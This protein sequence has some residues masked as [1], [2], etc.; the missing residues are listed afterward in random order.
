MTA[1]PEQLHELLNYCIGFAEQMLVDSGEFYP[2]GAT[3]GNDGRV[4]AVGGHI[5]SEHPNPRELYR[6]L[7][8]A[9]SAQGRS[10][11]ILAAAVASNVDIPPK[12]SPKYPDGLRVQVESA[13]YSRYI[14]VPY[15]LA[16]SGF[17]RKRRTL[18]FADPFSIEIEPQIFTF[19][20]NA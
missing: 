8:D 9:F 15:S 13:G 16:K 17:F 1:T 20:A 19:G 6:F 10:G 18:S 5:G 12:H 14:Y 2:F 4:V 7:A 11:E 3:V